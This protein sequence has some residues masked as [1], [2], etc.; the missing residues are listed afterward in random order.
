MRPNRPK[1]IAQL[2]RHP[3]PGAITLKIVGYIWRVLT[4]LLY[5]AVVLYALD[6]LHGRTETLT[7]STLGL[8]YVTI[9]TIAWAN[10]SQRSQ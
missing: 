4:N 5:L 8:I 10:L 3:L 6:Q 1:M 2:F 7:I 9:R